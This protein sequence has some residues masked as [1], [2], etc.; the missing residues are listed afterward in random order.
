MKGKR[1]ERVADL[2]VTV[3]GEEVDQLS[4]ALSELYKDRG[5]RTWEWPNTATA[6]LAHQLTG[7]INDNVKRKV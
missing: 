3:T 5:R 6:D 7:F 1:V 2:Q 4:S